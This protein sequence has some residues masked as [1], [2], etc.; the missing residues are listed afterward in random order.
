MPGQ[1]IED[2]R[3]AV[4][5]VFHLVRRVFAVPCV[6]RADAAVGVSDQKRQLARR[7]DR[8]AA[9][10]IAGIDV[11][12]IGDAVARHV[13]MVERLAELLRRKDL[14]CDGAA[15]GFL[16]VGAP[17]LDCLLQRMRRR[18]PV[19]QLELELLVVG[20]LLRRRGAD[21]KR[22]SEDSR[23]TKLKQAHAGAS[24]PPVYVIDYNLT[25][26][27][28]FNRKTGGLYSTRPPRLLAH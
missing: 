19:R 4:F 22:K 20:R 1:R 10:L 2:E 26:C 3:E 12:E 16:D 18:Y 8:E 23:T 13:V 6:D 17:V 15:G 9:G 21:P 11:G 27:A 28:R 7:D 14:V 24:C 5:H 25:H